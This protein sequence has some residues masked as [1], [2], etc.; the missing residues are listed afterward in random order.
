MKNNITRFNELLSSI[1]DSILEL[2]NLYYEDLQEN[3][4]SESLYLEKT[5]FTRTMLR[6]LLSIAKGDLLPDAFFIG[7][8]TA[9]KM[10]STMSSEQ[11][12]KALHEKVEVVSEDGSHWS[13][14]FEDLSPR[15]MNMVYDQRAKVFRSEDGQRDWL[16]SNPVVKISD[17]KGHITEVVKDKPKVKE[18]TKAKLIKE[19]KEKGLTAQDLAKLA[20]AST[21]MAAAQLA[22][23][24]A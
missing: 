24:K 23:V 16:K 2:A 10:V 21:L 15:Q 20:D 11:Q 7:N 14:K 1:Q 3:D 9:Y 19:L 18:T 5:F 4:K 6:R 8:A 17:G 22:L 12:E 13:K